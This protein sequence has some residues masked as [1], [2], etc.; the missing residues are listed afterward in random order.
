MLTPHR[1]HTSRARCPTVMSRDR[2]EG[3]QRTVGE[4]CTAGTCSEYV[5]ARLPP[6]KTEFPGRRLRCQ[7]FP[8][9]RSVVQSQ[10]LQYQKRLE[11]SQ[12]RVQA[13]TVSGGRADRLLSGVHM[14]PAPSQLMKRLLF[15][16]VS[17]LSGRVLGH[18]SRNHIK[19]TLFEGL[20]PRAYQPGSQSCLP[21]A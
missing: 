12:V 9:R 8:F 20:A 10:E 6:L 21:I 2:K 19:A 7:S 5:W 15:G 17:T 14:I 4:G 1:P 3:G 16:Q 13:L 18:S 11:G